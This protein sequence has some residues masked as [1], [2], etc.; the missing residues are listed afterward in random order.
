MLPNQ[1][2]T[3]I[4]H[5]D[6]G[7]RGQASPEMEQRI[8]NDPEA[9][10]EWQYIRVAVDAVQDAGLYAQVGAVKA[11][12]QAQQTGAS[13]AGGGTVRSMYRSAFRVA[14]CLVIVSGI[15]SLTKYVMTSSTGVYDKYYTSYSLNTSRS[16]NP[17]DVQQQAYAEKNWT[18][19]LSAFDAAKEKSNKT[20]FLAGMADLELKKYDDAI[21][22]FQHIIAANALS[23]S[24][25]FQDEAEFYLAMSWLGRGDSGEALPLLEKIKAN[26][27]H[28]YH[29]VVTKMSSLDLKIIQFKSGK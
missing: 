16:A 25:Y 18:G 9:A 20:Y 24:D 5:L 8:S 13:G 12:W 22:K 2:E 4:D 1:P 29:G 14:A 7:L 21:T 19:V 23:G 11:E 10:Q 3:L 15:A 17:I 27:N 26:N 6:S 28:S